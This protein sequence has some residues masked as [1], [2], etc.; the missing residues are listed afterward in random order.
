[1]ST[2][3]PLWIAEADVVAMMH[4]GQAIEALEKGLKEE[5]GGRAK[6]M[7]KT[8][9]TFGHGDTLHAIGATFEGAGI[10][11]T[12]TWAHTEGGGTPLLVLWDAHSGALLAIIEA[13]A[14]GQMRTA[15]MS[16]VA[17]KFMA[18]PDAS[19]F[20][21]IGTGKQAMAQLAAVAAV[22]SLREA[23]V[24]GRDAVKRAKFAEAASKLGF[25]F[26]LVISDSVAAAT[27]DADIVTLVTRA[28]EPIF[29]GAMAAKGAHLNAI[30]AIVPEREEF[31]QDIMARADLVAADDPMTTR[32][33]SKEFRTFF[34]ASDEA[35]KVVQPISQLIGNAQPRGASVD[36]SIFK[37]M[38]MGVSDLAL[39]IELYRNALAAG[40]GRPIE[41]PR[42]AS[43]RLNPHV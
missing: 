16:G 1:M 35:W 40:K 42:K 11:G 31:S 28:Q 38:G 41:S 22:R 27:K 9:A 18:K 8:H 2:T 13:F 17:T 36:I 25:K 7:A 34:G 29:T 30:G 12:K 33:L 23:R 10:I 15:A 43:P 32:R 5:A 39:G 24:F 21:L 20:A 26:K 37:A 3:S 6:N 14:M 19:V 4:L